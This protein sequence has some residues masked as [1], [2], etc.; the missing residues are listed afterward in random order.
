MV[1]VRQLRGQAHTQAPQ[2][3]PTLVLRMRTLIL[4]SRYAA[5]LHSAANSAV[6]G[7]PFTEGLRRSSDKAS[8]VASK[9]NEP[10]RIKVRH[11]GH[12]LGHDSLHGCP[13]CPFAAQRSTALTTSLIHAQASSG[14]AA[15]DR[16]EASSKAP[17][18]EAGS[19]EPVLDTKG[20]GQGKPAQQ[21]E[22]WQRDVE[23]AIHSNSA[24]QAANHRAGSMPGYA[25]RDEVQVSIGSVRRSPVSLARS[26]CLSSRALRSMS[27]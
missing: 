11:S 17:L 16:A 14:Q 22:Q 13:D 15:Q 6:A 12:I 26:L 27:T 1:Q 21:A 25:S 3:A 10:G 24:E 4:P 19:S 23:P 18:Q 9:Q 5:K 7:M 2:W 20:P 8:Y